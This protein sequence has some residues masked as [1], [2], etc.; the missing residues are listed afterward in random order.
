MSA[1]ELWWSEKHGLIERTNDRPA[2]A[3]VYWIRGGGKTSLRHVGY[4]N[5][6]PDDAVAL[7]PDPTA[8]TRPARI[9]RAERVL[10]EFLN[11]LDEDPVH[12]L[13]FKH[14]SPELWRQLREWAD[15]TPRPMSNPQ[16]VGYDMVG[17]NQMIP[18][19]RD[20]P[21]IHTAMVDDAPVASYPNADPGG[22]Y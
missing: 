14:D 5:S 2:N 16:V 15:H 7:V 9:A 18:V 21:P 20:V 22:R 1:P 13:W 4:K 11:W 6:L 8:N 3:S 12:V 10:R 17:E 19:V